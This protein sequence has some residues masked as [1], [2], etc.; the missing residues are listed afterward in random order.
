MLVPLLGDDVQH[1]AGRLP[2]LGG[3]AVGH[4]LEFLDPVLRVRLGLRAVELHRV[5]RAVDEHVV[6]ELALARGGE[7]H[8][9]LSGRRDAGRQLRELGEVAADRRQVVDLATVDQAADGRPR[10]DERAHAADEDAFRQRAD[11]E[12]DVERRFLADAEHTSRFAGANPASS[13]VSS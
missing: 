7:A 9:A 11:L 4:H 12:A 6:L 2:E 8:R 13:I 3:E 10:F 5:G 1:G